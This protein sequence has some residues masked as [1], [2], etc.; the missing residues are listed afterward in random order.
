MKFLTADQIDYFS[1]P[2]QWLRFIIPLIHASKINH[3][4]IKAKKKVNYFT[5]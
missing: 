4:K 3:P 2:E 5:K 1:D